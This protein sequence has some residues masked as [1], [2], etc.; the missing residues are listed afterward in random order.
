M[1]M[2]KKANEVQNEDLKK[3]IVVLRSAYGKVGQ[4]YFIQPCRDKNGNLPAC[5]RRIDA[6][7]DMILS[8]ED[9]QQSID[10]FIPENQ[11]FVIEDGKTF[12]LNDPRQNAEWEAIKN[13][14]LIAES[15]D[16]KDSNGDYLIDGTRDPN[17]KQPRYGR[18]ELYV[19]RPGI[20]SA[21]RV[22]RQKLIIKA[23]NFIISDERGYD[24]HLII[25]KV[26]GRNMTNQPA[27]DVEDYLLSV[28]DKTPEKIIELYTGGDLQ[29]KL[30]FITA[31]EKGVIRKE[32][33]L[34]LFGEDDNVTLGAS[35]SAV[36]EWMKQPRNQK[37]LQLIRQETYPEV[38]TDKS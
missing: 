5:V 32:H 33:G 22:T 3:N 8:I 14:F 26:L 1:F 2:A 17:S 12:D 4:Q 24:G 34:Y 7:G 35:D 30:L 18:A 36:L 28:A 9:R 29:L 10:N 16:A 37:T 31:K 27:A 13:C 19:E 11:I 6:Q 20:I 23:K 15:R 21:R 38:Y 25:A